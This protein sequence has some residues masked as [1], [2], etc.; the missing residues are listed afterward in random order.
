MDQGRETLDYAQQGVGSVNL[1]SREM[2]AENE[3]DFMLNAE[4]DG[5]AQ[6]RRRAMPARGGR[7]KGMRLGP[8]TDDGAT[9]WRGH[10]GGW[11]LSA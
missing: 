9:W 4:K 1:P 7:E 10:Y 6:E 3:D 5:D 2:A 11:N 8:Q